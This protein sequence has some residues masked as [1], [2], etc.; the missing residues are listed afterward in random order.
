MLLPP[1][2]LLPAV[3]EMMPPIFIIFA[4]SQPT[5]ID[6]E[7]ATSYHWHTLRFF[8]HYFDDALPLASPRYFDVDVNIFARV[9]DAIYA[10]YE[11]Y[12][13]MI[14][15]RD[16]RVPPRCRLFRAPAVP[17]LLS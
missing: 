10:A 11:F 8:R 15:Q 1:L 14:A 2:L 6:A 13:F 7:I 12:M 17:R 16:T 3:D 9:I 4:A 5:P